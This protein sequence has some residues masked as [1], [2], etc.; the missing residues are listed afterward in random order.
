MIGHGSSEA[1]WTI[2]ENLKLGVP[3]LNQACEASLK[4]TINRDLRLSQI[5]N[6]WIMG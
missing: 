1:R 3:A 2:A 5:S 4:A 6:I